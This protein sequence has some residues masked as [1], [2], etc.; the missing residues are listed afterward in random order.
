MKIQVECP[1][2][3]PIIVPEGDFFFE[4]LAA[5]FAEGEK[6]ARIGIEPFAKACAIHS[7]YEFDSVDQR[8]YNKIVGV[9]DTLPEDHLLDAEI[10]D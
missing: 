1:P 2:H 9:I 4:P 7:L 5:E 8:L 6:K 10:V 3:T